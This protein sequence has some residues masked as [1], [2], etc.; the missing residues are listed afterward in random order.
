MIQTITS[1]LPPVSPRKF[2]AHRLSLTTYVAESY[3]PIGLVSSNLSR[4][5]SCAAIPVGDK[6]PLPARIPMFP[7]LSCTGGAG[8]PIVSW[9]EESNRQSGKEAGSPRHKSRDHSR[10]AKCVLRHVIRRNFPHFLISPLDLLQVLSGVSKRNMASTHPFQDKV[11]AITGAS[12]GTGLALTR[13]LLVRGAKVSMAATS[14]DNLAK[15]VA[16]IEKDIPNTE[17]R[18]MTTVVDISKPEDVKN[19]IE[20]TV[21]KW[22]PLDGSANVAGRRKKNSKRACLESLLMAFLLV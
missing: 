2:V 11:I 21:E 8:A 10:L 16:E 19:W 20:K 15:A 14:A 3:R 22:G 7:T 4:R 1:T 18:V 12:R 13:Y 5:L 6:P 17:G 9:A